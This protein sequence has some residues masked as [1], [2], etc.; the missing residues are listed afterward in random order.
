M[1]PP[2]RSIAVL[3]GRPDC[4]G[5]DGV[6]YQ[7]CVARQCGQATVVETRARKTKPQWQA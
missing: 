4:V 5:Y 7:A 6:R 1:G 3:L 2:G